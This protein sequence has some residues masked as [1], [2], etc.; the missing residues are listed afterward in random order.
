MCGDYRSPRGDLRQWREPVLRQVQV[1]RVK[2]GTEIA[3][4]RN[5]LYAF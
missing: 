3:K 1:S 5:F 4:Q 2:L